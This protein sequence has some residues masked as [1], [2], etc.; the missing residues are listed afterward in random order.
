MKHSEEE[1]LET[2]CG[3]RVEREAIKQERSTAKTNQNKNKKNECTLFCESSLP[4][5]LLNDSPRT[6]IIMCSTRLVMRER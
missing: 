6:F 4:S 1:E 2:G 5:V 3:E